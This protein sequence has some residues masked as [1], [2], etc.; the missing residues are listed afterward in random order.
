MSEKAKVFFPEWIFPGMD[1]YSPIR[2]GYPANRSEVDHA[3][4]RLETGAQSFYY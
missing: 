2:S 3:Y 4:P 1:T